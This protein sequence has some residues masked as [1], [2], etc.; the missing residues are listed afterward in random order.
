M[1]LSKDFFKQ[2]AVSLAKKLLGMLLIRE[3]DDQKIICRI[4]E[5]EAYVGP[6][7]KACH[8]Y[9]NRRTNRT[10]V[11]F[12]EGGSAY[13]YLIYGMYYCLNIVANVRDKP[14][15]VLIRAVEPIMGINLIKKN[16]NIKSTKVE[17]LTNGPGKLTQALK[18]DTQLNQHKLTKNNDLY[19]ISDNNFSTESYDIVETKRINIDYAEEYKDKLWRFYLKGNPFISKN[20]P[21][22]NPVDHKK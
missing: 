13:I 21:N 17:N 19:I 18:I 10:E 12:H 7:D 8:A 20:N 22:I 11:M 3:I 15:A 5:T 1:N 4:V 9:N 16:R 6:E 14:E 2:D